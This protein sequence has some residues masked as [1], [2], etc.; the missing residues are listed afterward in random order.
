MSKGIKIPI[1]TCAV[2]GMQ[3]ATEKAIADILL[4][5]LTDVDLPT[6]K[7]YFLYTFAQDL[8]EGKAKYD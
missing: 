2:Y 7:L 1:D 6:H 4:K 3:V 8:K 5:I